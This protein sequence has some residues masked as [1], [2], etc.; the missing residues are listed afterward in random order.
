[1]MPAQPKVGQRFY[2][3]VAPGVAMDRCEIVSTG[4]TVTTPAGKF[5]NCLKTA[6]DTPLEKN[7]RESKFYAPDVG[8]VAEEDFRLIQHGKAK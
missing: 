2:Q 1:M 8:L 3:E 5:A 6:E 7:S 4:E